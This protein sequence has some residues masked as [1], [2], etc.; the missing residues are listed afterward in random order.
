VEV[1]LFNCYLGLY[2][3]NF[4]KKKA[5][6]IYLDF[7]KGQCAAIP[8]LSETND[9]IDA[10]LS[11]AE[12]KVTTAND[13]D[14]A[15]YHLFTIGNLSRQFFGDFAFFRGNLIAYSLAST[16]FFRIIFN[17]VGLIFVLFVLYIAFLHH[18]EKESIYSVFTYCI[19]MAHFVELSCSITNIFLPT[20][21]FQS[22]K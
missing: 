8:P 19:F 20:V 21:I 11:T 16:Q 9:Y 18:H 17:A 3:T 4:N 2:G 7:S 14:D 10:F 12:D 15:I 22:H 13:M 6:K 5:K 1:I